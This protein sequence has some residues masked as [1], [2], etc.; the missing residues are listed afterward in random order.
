[1]LI[2][3][4]QLRA[5]YTLLEILLASAIALILLAALYV[6]MD[7]TLVRMD[8]NRDLV[9]ANDFSRAIF[10][11]MGTDLTAGLGVLPPNSGGANAATPDSGSSGASGASS[12]PASSTPASTTGTGSSSTPSSSSG[13]TSTPSTETSTDPSTTSTSTTNAPNLNFQSG[14]LGSDKYLTIFTSRVP[15]ALTDT[16][17][18]ANPDAQLPADLQRVTFYLGTDGGLC[19]QVRPWV[20]ADGV[21]NN[22][23]PDL[24]TEDLDTIAPEVRDVTFEYFD[25]G[26]W[27]GEWDG[28]QTGLDG[29]TLTGPPRAIRVTLVIEVNGRGNVATQKTVQ[30]VFVVRAAAG[31]YTPP[32]EETTTTT[33][34][35]M[36]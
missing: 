5:G 17:A 4:K 25:G 15:Q 20:T 36:P 8:A 29:V 24:S 28:T 11:R 27:L 16:E 35:T 12:T 21:G 14:V 26:V 1:M 23:E 22:A 6:A 34:G 32:T 19:R 7:V 9:N 10:N 30:Q 31:T 33:T 3:S 18:A 2:R 13:S